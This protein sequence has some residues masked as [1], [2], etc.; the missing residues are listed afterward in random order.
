MNKILKR[1][2]LT[3]DAPAATF[4]AKSVVSDNIEKINHASKMNNDANMH[5]I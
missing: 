3:K 4:T 1:F 5:K 2:Y